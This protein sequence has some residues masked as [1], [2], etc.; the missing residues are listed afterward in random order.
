[1]NRR[2]LKLLAGVVAATFG[3]SGNAHSECQTDQEQNLG[4]AFVYTVGDFAGSIVRVAQ[5]FTV[6]TDGDLAEVHVRGSVSI[7]P[8][9]TGPLTIQI[10]PTAGG[11]PDESSGALLTKVVPFNELPLGVV[12]TPEIVFDVSSFAVPVQTGEVLALVLSAPSGAFLWTFRPTAPYAGGTSWTREESESSWMQQSA[13]TF[14]RTIVCATA[15]S[16]EQPNISANSW[17]ET[18]GA[19]RTHSSGE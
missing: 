17:G 7:E 6:G 15:V 19:Y 8:A 14:F 16:A 18:K 3:P 13:D 5:T 9:G 12:P 1:M 2:T 10:F 11:V 4:S